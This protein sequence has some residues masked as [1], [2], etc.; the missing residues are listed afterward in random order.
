MQEMAAKKRG[1]ASIRMLWAIAKSPE[2]NL[3][4][5]NLYAVIS[6]ETGKDSM[7]KLTKAEL[8]WVAD[9][10]QGMKDRA[11]GRK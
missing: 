3:D 5:E 4:K 9:V 7:A 10:L 6:R 2:L 8:N 11:G 1:Q